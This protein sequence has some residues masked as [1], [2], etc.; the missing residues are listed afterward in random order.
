MSAT[1]PVPVVTSKNAYRFGSFGLAVFVAVTALTSRMFE[2]QLLPAPAAYSIS[3]GKSAESVPV[4]SSR[5]LIYSG[6]AVPVLL[7]E[8][9]P[10]F[11]VEIVRHDLPLEQK[12]M[13]V[14]RLSS[15]LQLDAATIDS[16]L[17]GATGSIFDPV[18]VATNVPSDIARVVAENAG[19]L[20]GVHVVSDP[21]RNYP[22][23]PLFSEIVGYTSGLQDVTLKQQQAGYSRGDPIGQAGLESSYEDVL[24][25]TY[26]SQSQTLDANGQPI[27]GLTSLTTPPVPGS[28]LT[29]S[30]NAKE[31]QYAHTALQWGVSAAHV[32]IG[33][34]I[35]ENPQNGEILAMDSLP[36][37]D[38]N[39]IRTA[40]Q[41]Q[42]QAMLNDKSGMM[43]NKAVAEQFAPGSTY[44]LV[45][46]IAGL[47][48]GVI[49]AD[50]KINSLPYYEYYGTQYREWNHQG[51]GPLN[52][53]SGLAHSSDTFFYQ[54]AARVGKTR[55]AYW[56]SQLGF[57]APTGIDLPN[58]ASGIVPSDAWKQG[59]LGQPMLPGEVIQSGI[60]QGYDAATPLQLLNAY[61]AL[62]NGG[63]VWTPHVVKSITDPNGNVTTIQPT[64][65]RDLVADGTVSPQTLQTMREGTRAVITSRHTYDFVDLPIYAMGK[66]GTAEFGT[67]VRGVLPYHEWFVGYTPGDAFNGNY[68]T[69][70][71]QLAV[72]A[73]VYGANTLGDV[74][75][76]I[77]K[78]YMWLHYHLGSARAIFYSRTPGYI[79]PWITKTSNFYYVTQNH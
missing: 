9:L 66:T 20:P 32:K 21:I 10:N 15:V 37:Y 2:L 46:G 56:G 36:E 72:V 71:S 50:T 59:V 74:A 8:N 73:F 41:D 30:I 29:L 22:M 25:G 31:Q 14:S 76:E 78:Y 63:K 13:V 51:W 62:A 54:L 19:E 44:K 6:D 26:G 33:V 75:T 17:D 77:V 60:G 67:V 64:L 55:L 45:T 3:G 7:A 70:D 42:F 43:I 16:E 12:A 58:E 28:S 47:S 48:D 49:T 57:G 27:A 23:G 18:V 35:V 38:D 61:C 65:I 68:T 11:E 24:R 5:G 40:S 39:S 34:I 69:T 53:V 4:P 79:Y 1:F 52:I